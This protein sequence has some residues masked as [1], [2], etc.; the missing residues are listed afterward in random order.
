MGMELTVGGFQSDPP[1]DL[2]QLE[3]GSFLL[4][5]VR[6]VSWIVVSFFRSL[7]EM[8]HAQSN[9]ESSS[10]GRISR[11]T[12]SRQVFTSS[13]LAPS[14]R[15][16]SLTLPDSVFNSGNVKNNIAKSRMSEKPFG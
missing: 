16:T 7:L 6:L 10:C 11:A 15:R 14:V 3:F 12:S 13:T 9:S 5:L 2:K 1:T 8:A 4:V